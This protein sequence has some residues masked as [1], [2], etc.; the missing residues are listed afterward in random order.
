MGDKI[1]SHIGEGINKVVFA[2]SVLDTLSNHDEV[3]IKSEQGKIV[4]FG[5]DRQIQDKFDKMSFDA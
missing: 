1:N 2:N 4:V 5:I 3:F